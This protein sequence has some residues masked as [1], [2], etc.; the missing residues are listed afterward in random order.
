[1]AKK[2]QFGSKVSVATSKDLNIIL[3]VVNFAGNPHDSKTIEDTLKQVERLTGQHVEQAIVDRG[4]RSKKTVNGTEI[5]SPKP[6]KSTATAYQKAKMRGNFRRRAAIEP[7]IGHMLNDY[8]MNRNYLKGEQG[9]IINAILSGAAFNFKRWLNQKLI[10]ISG[11]IQNWAIKLTAQ[12]YNPLLLYQ[13][14]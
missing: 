2:F 3:S 10:E 8:R 11:F 9:D 4:Y 13:S 1:V 7:I 5:I 6:L 14:C 12:K